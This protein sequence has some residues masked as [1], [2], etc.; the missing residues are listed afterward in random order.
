MSTIARLLVMVAVI[1]CLFP[2]ASWAACIDGCF[3]EYTIT[4]LE[5]G[6]SGALTETSGKFCSADD[7]F[8]V[9]DRVEVNA[10]GAG[11]SATP[12]GCVRLCDCD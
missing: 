6:C 11:C 2:L 3:T 7:S 8:N 10:I 5:D 12:Q 1:S 9:N 4:M